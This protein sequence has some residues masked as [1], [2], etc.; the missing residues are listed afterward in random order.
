MEVLG[1]VKLSVD[2]LLCL[3]FDCVEVIYA[4]FLA[5]FVLSNFVNSRFSHFASLVFVVLDLL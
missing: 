3:L 4:N 1:D 5:C 2:F